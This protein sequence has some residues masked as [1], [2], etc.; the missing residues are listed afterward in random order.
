MCIQARNLVLVD[1][2]AKRNKFIYK[3]IFAQQAP[4]VSVVCVPT[5]MLAEQTLTE[6]YQARRR[7]QVAPGQDQVHIALMDATSGWNMT[8]RTVYV[9]TPGRLGKMQH[10]QIQRLILQEA[11]LLLTVPSIVEMLKSLSKDTERILLAGSLDPWFSDLL[12]DEAVGGPF[13]V[14]NSSVQKT[15]QEEAGIIR[16]HQHHFAVIEQDERVA[17]IALATALTKTVVF[18]NSKAELVRLMTC[19]DKATT[20]WLF[21]HA[22]QFPSGKRATLRLFKDERQTGVLVTTDAVG[23]ALDLSGST[24]PVKRVVHLEMPPTREVYMARFDTLRSCSSLLT[25]VIVTAKKKDRFTL[26]RALGVRIVDGSGG[27]VGGSDLKKEQTRQLIAQLMTENSVVLDVLVQSEARRL[28]REA[29]DK[30]ELLNSAMSLLIKET[31]GSMGGSVLSGSMD[32]QSVLLVDP[33][34]RTIKTRA[35][36]KRAVTNSARLKNGSCRIGRLA[37]SKYGFIVDIPNAL[38][39]NLMEKKKVLKTVRV[40]LLSSLPELVDDEQAHM[41]RWSLRDKRTL[42]HKITRNIRWR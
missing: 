31:G 17:A 22:G 27:L 41:H 37:L 14:L 32:H 23:R 24:A 11:D 28:F 38:V 21:L 9:T 34:M 26:Q 30:A 15:R 4:V 42:H 6:L 25:S 13:H 36:A 10:G 18:V 33:K 2:L 19:Q 7:L 1:E 5:R 12:Q 16:Q 8:G 29:T 39:G 40:M 35:E 3:Q 20:G